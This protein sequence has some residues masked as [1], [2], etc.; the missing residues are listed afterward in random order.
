MSCI[1][2]GIVFKPCM[3]TAVLLE[4]GSIGA[5]KDRE[6]CGPTSLGCEQQHAPME[7]DSARRRRLV[8]KRI[9]MH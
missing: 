8:S 3:S 9:A 1:I 4:I 2:P 5:E 7:D 6:D